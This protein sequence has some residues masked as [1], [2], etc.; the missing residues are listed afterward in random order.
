MQALGIVD[1]SNQDI[2]II[3][4]SLNI[5]IIAHDSSLYLR[6]RPLIG[7]MAIIS[8]YQGFFYAA[9]SLKTIHTSDK[10]DKDIDL[11]Y[12]V[13]V[14]LVF[15]IDLVLPFFTEY[16]TDDGRIVRK[17]DKIAKRYIN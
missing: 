9:F 16:K 15:L 2:E 12:L 3:N 6:S 17:L 4:N 13:I 7:V 10:V 14:E 8:S 11:I 1:G 5:Q